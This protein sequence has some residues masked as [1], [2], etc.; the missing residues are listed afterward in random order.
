MDRCDDSL[1]LNQH[2]RAWG[3]KLVPGNIKMNMPK[4]PIDDGPGILTTGTAHRT[5]DQI[6]DDRLNG[7]I[8]RLMDSKRQIEE[9]ALELIGIRHAIR[10]E[11][12]ND[13][14]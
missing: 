2:E 1:E 4:G 8:N 14:D 9:I 13:K 7:L 5:I 6:Q 10:E 11:K 12:L 3:D